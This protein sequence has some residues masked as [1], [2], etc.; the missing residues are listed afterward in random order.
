MSLQRK[1]TPNKAIKRAT[2]AIMGMLISGWMADSQAAGEISPAEFHRA[3]YALHEQIVGKHAVRMEVTEADYEGAS[4]AG[5]RYNETRYY[6]AKDGRFLSRV[7][8]D[9]AAPEAVLIVE[10]NIYNDTGQIVRDFASA[11][12]PWQPA[13]PVNTFINL[14]HYQ[15]QLHSFRQYDI[16]GDARYQACDGSFESKRVS[17]SLYPEDITVERMSSPVYRACFDGG[18][19]KWKPYVPKPY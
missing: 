6:D 11:S 5:Y 9:A 14:H 2:A 15:A 8:R 10:V 19:E 3:L 12:M 18:N 1:S 4:G 16:Y 7:R 13:I 17:L